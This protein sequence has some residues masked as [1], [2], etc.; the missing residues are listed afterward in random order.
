MNAVTPTNPQLVE[1][2]LK[3]LAVELTGREIEFM[4]HTDESDD[5]EQEMERQLLVG[6]VSAELECLLRNEDNL[7]LLTRYA[8]Q[9]VQSLRGKL[10]E[11]NHIMMR[12]FAGT[13]IQIK[14]FANIQDD[15]HQIFLRA[16]S[17]DYKSCFVA[18]ESND[19]ILTLTALEMIT[20]ATKAI[21]A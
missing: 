15:S 18:L 9:S 4:V 8:T 16:Y 19:P 1:E 12:D 6:E 5:P 2:Q 3:T 17:T 10:I 7:D 14:A 13:R 21:N 20:G 11:S